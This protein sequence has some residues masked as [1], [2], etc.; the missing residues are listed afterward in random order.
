[1]VA[2]VGGVKGDEG[3][4]RE[5]L[6]ALGGAEIGVRNKLIHGHSSADASIKALVLAKLTYPA[7][8]VVDDPEENTNLHRA[9]YW[10]CWK[11]PVRPFV[12]KEVL[13]ISPAKSDAPE[14]P[15]TVGVAL[16]ICFQETNA[17]TTVPVFIKA[18]KDG[19]LATKELIRS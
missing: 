1:L 10:L 11:E 17:S 3:V 13:P 7:N 4:V 9:P 2:S 12:A 18:G 6:D 8:P 5:A 15:E 14:E 19:P 16:L